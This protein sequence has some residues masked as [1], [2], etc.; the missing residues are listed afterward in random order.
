MQMSLSFGK[1]EVVRVLEL[2]E[3]SIDSMSTFGAD[4]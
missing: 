2:E 4:I 3:M 1:S